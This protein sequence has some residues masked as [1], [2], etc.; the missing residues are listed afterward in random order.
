MAKKEEVKPEVIEESP[1]K[2]LIELKKEILEKTNKSY[3]ELLGCIQA[4]PVDQKVFG[5]VYHKL[6]TAMLWFQHLVRSLTEKPTYNDP[7]PQEGGDS[8]DKKDI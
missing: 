1:L 5:H 7:T 2:T 3:S 8:Q 6:E 4:V